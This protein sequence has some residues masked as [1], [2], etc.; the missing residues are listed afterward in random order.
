MRL[1]ELRKT[2][3]IDQHQRHSNL[4]CAHVRNR[5]SQR[6]EPTLRGMVVAGFW[7]L[8]E[9][10]DIRPLL[11]WLHEQGAHVALPAVAGPGIPLEFHRWTPSDTLTE[12]AFG[13]FEPVR[14]RPLTPDAVLVP[15]LGFGPNGERLG[16]GGGYYDRSLA[17]L[18]QDNR[19]LVT[20]G[21]AWNEGRIPDAA[22]FQP[23]S[24]DFVLQAIATPAG[25]VPK[26]P[27]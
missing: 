16:Y 2:I 27:I 12:G 26:A 3:P 9:E 18:A 22:E 15:T 13:V 7:P 1:R 17:K 23:A 5:F 4:L 11:T 8:A 14:T 19:A 21:I 10:P 24:H 20:I 6:G 25:W